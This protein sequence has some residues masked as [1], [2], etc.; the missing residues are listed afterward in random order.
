MGYHALS[1][2]ARKSEHSNQNLVNLERAG[3]RYHCFIAS[4]FEP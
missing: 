2:T 4:I 1:D 3:I